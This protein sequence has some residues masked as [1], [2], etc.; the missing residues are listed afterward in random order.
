MVSVVNFQIKVLLLTALLSMVISL[1]QK[2]LELTEFLELI[3]NP[4]KKFNFMVEHNFQAFFLM[5]TDLLDL[6]QWK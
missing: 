3:M 2:W 6:T 1:I 4:S 5:P